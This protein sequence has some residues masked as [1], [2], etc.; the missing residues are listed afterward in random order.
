[1]IN[2]QFSILASESEQRLL[3]SFVIW[4]FAIGDWLFRPQPPSQNGL[5]TP[6]PKTYISSL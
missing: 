6:P 5:Y 1:M 3:F 2:D 4:L